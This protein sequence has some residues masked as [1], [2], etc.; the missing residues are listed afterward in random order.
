MDRSQA[1]RFQETRQMLNGV[2]DLIKQSRKRLWASY[3]LLAEAT[4]GIDH[5]EHPQRFSFPL[6]RHNRQA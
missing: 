4:G 6:L 5:V 1:A 3:R 2:Q